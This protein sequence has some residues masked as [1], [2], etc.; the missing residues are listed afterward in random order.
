MDRS[1]PPSPRQKRHRKGASATARTDWHGPVREIGC[2]RLLGK[3]ARFYSVLSPPFGN[4]VQLSQ[5]R[6]GPTISVPTE[7]PGVTDD[8]TGTT[9]W[10]DH[11]LG[12]RAKLRRGARRSLSFGRANPAASQRS[13][14]GRGKDRHQT[15]PIG[16]LDSRPPRSRGKK[17]AKLADLAV[18]AFRLCPTIPD[19]QSGAAARHNR[20]RYDIWKWLKSSRL[21]PT[22]SLPGGFLTRRGLFSYRRLAC[23]AAFSRVS[24]PVVMPGTKALHASP[25]RTASPAGS[26][27][28][29][30]TKAWVIFWTN[31]G[32]MSLCAVKQQ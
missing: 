9:I 13:P 12:A 29:I 4:R 24:Q 20:G 23:S 17:V 8:A 14:L 25:S 32:S 6:D 3:R 21:F 30:E 16:F 15:A 27:A 11:Q 31:A 18:F 28:S 22:G 1:I 7:R 2:Y 5:H 19:N 26:C 10:T